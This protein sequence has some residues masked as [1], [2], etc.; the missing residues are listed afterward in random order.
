VP[1]NLRNL[2]DKKM[3][4]FFRAKFWA[5]MRPDVHTV[6]AAIAGLFISVSVWYLTL[7]SE[8]RAYEAE[9]S[10]RANNQ[11][12]ILQSGIDNYW[13]KL[14]AVRALF[15]SDAS[16]S[17]TEFESF[18]KSLLEGH[19]AILN[20]SWLPLVKREERAAHEREALRDGLADYHI[21]A[22]AP[23]G[24]LPI[25]PEH[26]EYVPKF[27]STEARD[28]P[29]YGLDNNDGGGREQA[30]N[31]IRDGN[32][33]STS[34]P[35]ML[36]IGDGDRRGFWAGIPVYAQG[37]PH[38]TPEERHRNLRGIVQGV[39]QIGVM[40]D[41]IFGDVR[42][43]VR[44]YVFAPGAAADDEAF[45]FRSRFDSN[46][47]EPRSQAQLAHG[48]YRSYSIDI[49]DR[50]WTMMLT[51]EPAAAS[52]SVLARDQ[53][54]TIVLIC[55]LLLSGA[56]TAFVFTTRRY[57]QHI[58]A[59]QNRIARQNV[60][61]DA[62][63]NNMTQGLLMYDRDGKL[64]VT[65]RRMAQIFGM[66]WDAWQA[67]AIG[68]TPLQSLQVAYELTN[69]GM[70]NPQRVLGELQAILAS[71]KPNRIVFERQNGR[72]YSSLC[73]PMPDG[74]FVITFNDITE[75]RHA[76]EKIAHMA[77]HDALTDLLNRGQFYDKM[78]EFLH[79]TARRRRIAV[80]SMDLDRFK[81]VNDSLGHP[82]GDKLLQ[83]VAGRMR[84]CVRDIDVVARLGGDE[85]AVVQTSFDGP[86]DAVIL[87]GRLID[88]V[89]AP[90]QIDGHRITV[91]TSIGIAIAPQDGTEPELLMKNADAALYRAKGGGNAY[92]F[93]NDEFE[94]GFRRH[95]TAQPQGPPRRRV[96]A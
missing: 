39:F 83:A 91:G 65:N 29:V 11:R 73:S 41:G 36:H 66:P 30:L 59:A 16:V 87:A 25:S 37:R 42:T 88:A 67:T 72:S 58:E 32:I 48:L 13:D 6:T 69:V 82:I 35:L 1:A 96:H 80:L 62:A 90:Y 77:H 86:G 74:G 20:I 24:T 75:R 60:R 14:F 53:L 26:D 51:P 19:P 10:G 52:S 22:I 57:S 18:A 93:F 94:N 50:Q 31:R 56:L 8:H 46:P 40:I 2:A 85:F 5:R 4:R 7:A 9:F 44:L 95:R 38:D 43:P 70:K 71:G 54:S 63:L 23:D 81:H 12:T 49:G 61:F 17:R 34:P 89:S 15:D 68:T 92:Q 33:L 76:E 3:K 21:R 45:Y 78:N 79:G 55:G 64:S 47:I 28:S 84:A 27:Y